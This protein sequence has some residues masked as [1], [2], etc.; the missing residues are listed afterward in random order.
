MFIA[1]NAEVTGFLATCESPR[2]AVCYDHVLRRLVGWMDSQGLAFH[3]ITPDRFTQ[4]LN[5]QTTWKAVSRYLAYN[6]TRAFLRW[7]FGEDHSL[8]KMRMKR[9]KAKPQPTITQD[10]FDRLL[11]FFNTQTAIGARDL[12]LF[13]LAAETGLRATAL[14]NIKMQNLYLDALTLIALDKG[15]GGGEWRV[16]RF[17]PVVASYLIAWLAYREGIALPETS[18]IFCSVRGKKRGQ[19]NDRFGL[20]SRCREISRK[21]GFKFT[22]HVFRRFM[23]TRLLELGA[24]DTATM[25][26]GAWKSREEF[27]KYI[28]SYQ[29]PDVTPFSP[30]TAY[31]NKGKT[32]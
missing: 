16:C 11:P 7:R 24:S 14:C 15:R 10:Q 9:P 19:S 27:L 1:M 30:V 6:V 13:A 25:Q 32:T 5:S 28:R 31:Y 29:L 3:E 2:T 18:T 12:A 23:A 4:F 22:P 20:L 21:V 17:S 26:Q 8:S